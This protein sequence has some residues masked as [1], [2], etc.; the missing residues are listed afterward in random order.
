MTIYFVKK[1]LIKTQNIVIIK[2]LLF[3]NVLTIVLA[4]Y[5]N[6]SNVFLAKNVAEFHKYSR[7][8]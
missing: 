3:N 1:A 5:S 4:K 8:K 6:Y 7:N 2:V